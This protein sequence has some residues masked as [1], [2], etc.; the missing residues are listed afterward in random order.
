MTNINITEPARAELLRQVADSMRRYLKGSDAEKAVDFL[1]V[2]AAGLSTPSLAGRSAEELAGAVMSVWSF[3]QHRPSS[4]ANIRVFNP[5]GSEQGWGTSYAI[6]EIVNDDMSFLVDSVLGVLQSFDQPVQWLVH[7]ILCVTR[8]QNGV[9]DKINTGSAE[10]VIQIAFGP[11]VAVEIL[12]RIEGAINGAMH[13]ARSAVADFEL[14]RGLLANTA[15]ALPL[16]AERNFL[17]WL[18]DQNFVLLGTTTVALDH[19]L[20]IVIPEKRTALGVLKSPD[21]HLFDALHEPAIWR[22]ISKEAL[23]RFETVAIAKADIRSRVH[24]PQLYDVIVVK[25]RDSEG[26][27]A[28][29]SF[30]AGLFVA[31]AYNRNPRSIPFLREK[32]ELILQAAGVDPV[33]HDGRMLRHIL[34]T[35]PRDDLFQGNVHDILAAAQRI[36]QLQVRPEL[37]LFLRLDLFGRHLSAIIFA[38]RDRLDSALRNKLAEMLKRV[39]SGSIAGFA[40]ALGDGPLAR[41]NYTIAADPA[42]ARG[43]DAATLEVAMKEVARSFRERLHEA[44]M[45]A[46]GETAA[47]LMISKWGSAF[48]DVYTTKTQAMTAVEDIIAAESA[49]QAGGFQSTLSR[50]FGLPD[51]V[52]VLKLFHAGEPIALSDIVPL[53]E[54]LGLRVI[55]EVPYPLAP[56]GAFVVLHELTLETADGHA[57]DLPARGVLIQDAIMAAWDGRCEAD[58]FNRLILTGLNWREASLLRAMFKWCRQVRAPFSQSAVEGALAAHPVAANTLI[59][60]FHSRFDPERTRDAAAEDEL[61][62]QF[63]AQLDL[64]SS[65][66]EDRIL[67]RL[68]QLTDAVLRTNFYDAKSPVIALKIDSARA[69]AMPLPRPMVEIWVHGPRTEGCHLRGGKVA[70]GGIRWSDRRDDFRTEILGLM[71]A[72]MVKNVVIV[73]VGAKGGFVI[74]R[75]PVPTGNARAD[76]EALLAEAISCYKLLINAML[77]VTDNLRAGEIVPPPYVVRRDG[78][79]AYLVVAADKGTATFSDIANAIA[80]ERGFWLGDA[81]ASGGSVGYDHKAMGI[82]ARGAWVNI[83]HHFHELEIDIQSTTF[84]CAGVGDMSGDVF[85]N[86]LLVSRKT[87][88]RAAFDHRHIFLD[89][90]PDAES[91][92]D[93]RK[94][95]FALPRSSWADYDA[96]KLSPGGGVYSRQTKSILLSDAA[97]AMLGLS[98]NQQEPDAVIRAIL[99]MKVDMLY[100]G[101]IGTYVKSS[102]ES[103]ADADDRTNDAVRVNARDVRSRVIGEGANLAVTQAGRIE[104]AFSGVRINTDALDNSAGVS[105]SDHEVNIKILLADPMEAGKLTAGQRVELLATMTSEVAELVLRDNHQQSL[106]IS[107]DQIGGASD[108][109]AQNA[110]MSLLETAGILDRNVAGLPDAAA[111]KTRSATGQGLTRPE[112]CALMAYTKLHLAAVLDASSLVDDPALSGLVSLYFPKP[113]RERFAMEIGRHRLRREL[114]GTTVTNELVNRMGVAA[115]GRLAAEGGADLVDVA[116]AALV[117]DYA[118]GLPD[119]YAGVEALQHVPASARY[120]VLLAASRLQ[121]ATARVLL[122][123]KRPLPEIGE[124]VAALRAELSALTKAACAQVAESSPVQE[125]VRQGVPEILAAFAVAVPNLVA[126]PL[127]V[128]IAKAHTIPVVAAQLA[129]AQ[130][131]GWSAIEPLRAAASMLKTN[132]VWEARAVAAIGDDLTYL[133]AALANAALSEDAESRIL[134]QDHSATVNAAIDLAH[135]A[136]RNP[137]IVS[138]SVAVR[139]LSKALLIVR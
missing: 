1:D 79:D 73:P 68:Y 35:W 78:D 37:A 59:S 65:P 96:A 139:S 85:G 36:V 8:D 4:N 23:E 67:R 48:P 15:A 22:A 46:H 26:R 102:T 123:N 66:D 128:Q 119:V 87:L 7:P 126:G 72:Q 124:G 45:V 135:E 34:D 16:G 38:P 120:A 52:M 130:A 64:I 137:E 105:T 49:L 27:V 125:L 95:L 33:S 61:S 93:E 39:T 76:R 131:G 112:L 82:T 62:K 24:R 50:P 136:A 58:G 99:T 110:L 103:Q 118:F 9:L 114:I 113:L 116:H 134:P 138:L 28:G 31:D 132:G 55:E 30:F 47:T 115:F 41:V 81:F 70:R 60:M 89:P 107:L 19:A 12:K 97:M 40:L 11:E 3:M 98:Q 77:D 20:D 129:W 69:G 71:K 88:L 75:P 104:A 101:G 86:G 121:E 14:M 92:Y 56:Q 117:A 90:E 53:I 127:I 10:S 5:R 109:P 80:I 91:S 29:L 74:K 57:L 122:G 2:Y 108:L 54:S 63:F 133:Q 100:F 21:C 42:Q 43:L 18:A 17:D 83:A 84:T 94:R 25:Q 44:L 111:M 51:R 6:I 106:A 32:V 13:D